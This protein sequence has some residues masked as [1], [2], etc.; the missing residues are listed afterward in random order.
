M[1]VPVMLAAGGYQS[2][3]LLKMPGVGTFLPILAV[4]FVTAAVVGWLAI[5]W[6]LSYLNKHSLYIFA[7]YCAA[8]GLL[9]LAIQL[10]IK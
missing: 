6:L 7:G 2:L 5:K 9:V 1:S 8:V 10:V 3:D 4:G